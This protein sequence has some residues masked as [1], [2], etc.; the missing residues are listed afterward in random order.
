MLQLRNKLT[1]KLH[2]P[3]L[4][5]VRIQQTRHEAAKTAENKQ[6]TSSNLLLLISACH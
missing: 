4:A 1:I 6:T 3:V 5:A 2:Q